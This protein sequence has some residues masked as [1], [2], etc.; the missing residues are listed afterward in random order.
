[1]FREDHAGQ[2][3]W[4]LSDLVQRAHLKGRG[5]LTVER[6]GVGLPGDHPAGKRVSSHYL[7]WRYNCTD[8]ENAGVGPS[9]GLWRP[10]QRKSHFHHLLC[11]ECWKPP[12]IWMALTPYSS[13]LSCPHAARQQV[14]SWESLIKLLGEQETTPPSTMQVSAWKGWGSSGWQVW[15]V[16]EKREDVIQTDIAF[17]LLSSTGHCINWIKTAH[18]I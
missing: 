2:C 9:G 5:D 16:R 3:H 18:M 1:M 12:A 13:F 8:H 14:E 7:A 17:W 4:V 15:G 11:P 6:V 10:Q